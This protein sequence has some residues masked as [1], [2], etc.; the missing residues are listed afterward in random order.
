MV[1]QGQG[2]FIVLASLFALDVKQQQQKD[3][4]VIHCVWSKEKWY[5]VLCYILV[6]IIPCALY[7]VILGSL[8]CCRLEK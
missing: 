5:Y 6:R 4:T 3:Y 8:Y 7:L 1:N 2:Y